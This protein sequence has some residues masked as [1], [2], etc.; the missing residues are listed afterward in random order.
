MLQTFS[1]ESQ[2]IPSETNSNSSKP[3]INKELK[4]LIIVH[5]YA[6]TAV[7]LATN[8]H[9]GYPRRAIQSN[10]YSDPT[11]IRAPHIGSSPPPSHPNRI[12]RGQI[13]CGRARPK[14]EQDRIGSGD[15]GAEIPVRKKEQQKGSR[16]LTD[17][18]RSGARAAQ[19]H[20]R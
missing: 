8:T 1:K 16:F 11:R 13:E 5:A 19:R 7:S 6:A 14:L 10:Y 17:D 9:L 15:L 4:R 2:N 12:A 20:R 18:A 3:S